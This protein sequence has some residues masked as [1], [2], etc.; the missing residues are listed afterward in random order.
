MFNISYH[1]VGKG[2]GNGFYWN[3]GHARWSLSIS[4]VLV[5]PIV[6]GFTLCK[7]CNYA[8]VWCVKIT[9]TQQCGRENI[10]K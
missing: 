2:L 9:T 1:V 8:M 10:G 4:S 6:E 5:K 7:Y 3:K